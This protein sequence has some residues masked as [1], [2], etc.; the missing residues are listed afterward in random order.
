MQ[1]E[2]RSLMTRAR[3]RT[4][5]LSQLLLLTLTTA[6]AHA[7]QPA[8][9]L[10]ATG[11]FAVLGGTTVTNTG[12]SLINGDLGVWPGSAITGFPPG[13]V[14]GVI[15][16]T[17]AVAH[18]AQSDLVAA[19]NDAAG[20][21]PAV[22]VPADLGGLFL[23]AGVYRYPSAVKLT[24]D[25]TLDGEG[26]ADAVFIIQVGSAL[27]TAS[28]SRVVLVGDAQPCN[29]F[30]QIGSSATL[31]TDTTF[32]GN[33][34]SL[35]SIT[36]NT[37]AN[38]FGRALAR[39]GAVT[40]DT[41]VVNRGDCAPGTTPGG[42]SVTPGTSAVPAVGAVVGAVTGL[43]T[44]PGTPPGAS[45]PGGSAAP[46][47]GGAAPPSNGAAILTMIPRKL[48]RIVARFGVTRCTGGSY[49]ALVTGLFIRKVTF[50]VDGKSVGSAVTPPFGML[51]R[52][53]AG[54]HKLRARVSFTD[55]TPTRYLGFRWRTCAPAARSVAQAPAFTG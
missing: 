47:R 6:T 41:N 22:A 54:I 32:R 33:I 21:T 34:F 42:G 9:G 35:Q 46:P 5:L 30:W 44:G 4:L 24:G 38:L 28:G 10:G 26:N 50:F 3:R 19:Y 29:V 27:T 7:A 55:G 51:I 20:R 48:A 23:T 16:A 15:H 52:S 39:N 2:R 17:D 43:V 25:V 8:V 49:R 11:S 18:Q 53:D 31:G 12:N 40:L 1:H 36:M 13:V 45:A 14:N 37:R